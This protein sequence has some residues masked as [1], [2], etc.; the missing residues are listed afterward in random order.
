MCHG[1]RRTFAPVAVLIY[2][3]IAGIAAKYLFAWIKS[4]SI[5]ITDPAN[6]NAANDYVQRL[7]DITVAVVPVIGILLGAFVL[8]LLYREIKGKVST[9]KRNA[10]AQKVD[11]ERQPLL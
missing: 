5:Y 1:C 9:A 2:F 4:V 3:L 8:V 7:K 11:P 6:A 10:L